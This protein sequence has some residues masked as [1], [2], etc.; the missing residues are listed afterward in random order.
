MTTTKKISELPSAVTPLTGTEDIPIV[1]DGA[2]RRVTPNDIKEGLAADSHSHLLADIADAGTA[3]GANITD[4]AS[5]SQGT[6]ADTAVQPGDIGSAAASEASDFATA[7]QGAKADTAIQPEDLSGSAVNLIVNGG[8]LVSHRGQKSLTSSWQSAPVDLL[9]VRAQGSVS[10]GDIRQILGSY[11]LAQTGAACWVEKATLN[12]SGKIEF[13]MRIESKDARS[14]ANSAAAFSARVYHDTGSAED[15]TVLISKPDN[16]DDFSSVTQIDLQVVNIPNDANS[17]LSVTV[18]DMG[19]CRNGIEIVIS[20]DCGAVSQK[21]FFLAE[22]QLI[23]G[24]IVQ[25]FQ[26][27]PISEEERLVHRYLRPA[28][29]V[30]AVANSGSN[31]QATFQHPGMR[32]APTYEV[33][34]PIAMTDGY[35]ADRTQSQANIDSI[36]ENNAHHG[37]VDIAYFSGLTSGRHYIHRGTGGLILASAEL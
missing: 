8:C 4:F 24:N 25:P 18:P 10:N 33:D 21:N 2:T 27:R 9:S 35:Q 12:A 3:A 22:M 6:K 37:R 5:S 15:Y 14:L 11:T 19:D 28:M 36:H 13:R 29:L 32:A 26:Q 34:A 31:M 1:Q 17:D 7:A 23:K 16:E 20:I 30:A